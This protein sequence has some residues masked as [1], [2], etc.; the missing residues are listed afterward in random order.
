MAPVVNPANRAAWDSYLAPYLERVLRERGG[1]FLLGDT[2]SA[3]DVVVGHAIFGVHRKLIDRAVEGGSWLSAERTPL[4][5]AYAD[6]VLQRPACVL[7]YTAPK[8]LGPGV[9]VREARAPSVP[10][11]GARI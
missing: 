2:F 4:L 6:R 5:F 8:E 3:A 1:P 11:Q 10:V 7:A 9:L